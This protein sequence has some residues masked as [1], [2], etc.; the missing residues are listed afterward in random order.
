MEAYCEDK[1][2]FF[3]VDGRLSIEEIHEKIKNKLSEYL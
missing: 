3:V 1:D 2:R